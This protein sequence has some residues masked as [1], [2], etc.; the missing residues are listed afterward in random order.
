MFML[1]T[2]TS[3]VCVTF[4]N[5]LQ[6]MFITTVLVCISP[7]KPGVLESLLPSQKRGRLLGEL[8]LLAWSYTSD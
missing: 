8:S 3:M 2:V 5:F 4:L 1:I 6:V 7:T